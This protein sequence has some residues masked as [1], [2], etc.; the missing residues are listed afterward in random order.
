MRICDF[1]LLLCLLLLIE[2]IL[3]LIFISLTLTLILEILHGVRTNLLGKGE[4][5]LL[6]LD[7]RGIRDKFQVTKF[8]QFDNKLVELTK[9]FCV[10]PQL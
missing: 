7:L 2:L 5:L 9:E 10:I 4:G 8:S 6:S 1:S 3:L